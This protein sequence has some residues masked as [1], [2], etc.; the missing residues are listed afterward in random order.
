VHKRVIS[1]V[2]RFEIV[3]D[4]MP[5]IILRD[6]WCDVIVLNVYAPTEDKI[7]DVKDN[8]CE[9]LERMLAKFPKYHMKILLRDF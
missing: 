3:N 9:E 6:H 2:K 5:Y 7:D 4:R 8:I 1:A